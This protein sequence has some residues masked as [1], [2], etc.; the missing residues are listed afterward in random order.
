MQLFPR[1]WSLSIGQVD[2]TDLDLAFKIER[3]TRGAAG[4]AEIR[5]WNPAQRTVAAAERGAQIRL[6]AGYSGS[7]P[8]I[9]SGAIRSASVSREGPDR[10]LTILGRDNGS[11]YFETARLSRAYAPG[12]PLSSVIRDLVR[13]VQIGEGNLPE[14]IDS[15]RLRGGAATFESGYAIDG[16]ASRALTAL[17]SGAGYRWSVQHGAVLALRR[18]GSPSISGALLTPDT[19]LVEIPTWDARRRVLTARS[20]IRPGLEPGRKVRIESEAATGDFDIRSVTW[21]GDTRGE[22]WTAEMSLRAL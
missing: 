8:L 3:K 15:L 13:T 18:G 1:A 22:D 21:I 17:L 6:S 10:I 7:V 14:I 2:L 19:G 20:L 5:V 4:V 9:F 11:V 16:L 12:T